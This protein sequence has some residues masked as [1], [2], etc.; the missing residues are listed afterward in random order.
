MELRDYLDFIFNQSTLPRQQISFGRNQ[1]EH[2]GLC[3]GGA[4]ANFAAAVD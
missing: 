4:L 1:S 3:D 2:D